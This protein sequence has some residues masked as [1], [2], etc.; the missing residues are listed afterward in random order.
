[1]GAGDH[2]QYVQPGQRFE[3][4]ARTFNSFVDAARDFL[5]RQ[6]T[7]DREPIRKIE[8]TGVFPVRNDTGADQDQ[9]AVVGI[10]E[11]IFS[12]TENSR[13]FKNRISFKG[14]VPGESTFSCNGHLGRF[15][16]LQE[17]AR[18]GKLVP[19]VVSG[20]TV[21]KVFFVCET[22]DKADIAESYTDFLISR[23]D[24]SATV[25]Y[26][27]PGIGLKWAVVRLD[28]YQ[29][30]TEFWG[31][32]DSS[33]E[34]SPNKFEYTFSEVEYDP[35]EGWIDG[36]A[37]RVG[38]AMNTVEVPNQAT[39]VAGN[40]VDLDTGCECGESSSGSGGNCCYVHA[41]GLG[42]IVRIVRTGECQIDCQD[43]DIVYWFQYE[44][45]VCCCPCDS[46]SS[47]SSSSSSGD[48]SSSSS[49]SSSGDDSS[50]SSGDCLQ[51]LVGGSLNF[52]DIP[53][54]EDASNVQYILGVTENCCLV[55]VP[56]SSCECS[57]SGGSGN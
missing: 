46:S 41:V 44:N 15:A 28:R 34:I 1:M 45:Q 9:F 8:S 35:D 20:V 50:S 32:I 23:D 5:K 25:L 3:F 13:E 6:Q 48:D 24:G 7:I 33:T 14:I 21:A 29:P 31:R 12:P 47:S 2:L 27:E 57:S 19:A 11:T 51:D 22:H 18:A 43:G 36:G 55:R 56:V 52:C 39:G 38:T 49:S 16:I 10:D 4:K 42:A 53:I 30:P 37:G 54:V 26:K 17:P 40:G